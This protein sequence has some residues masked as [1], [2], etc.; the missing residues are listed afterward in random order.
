M[1]YFLDTYAIMEIIKG[2]PAYD[3]FVDGELFTSLFNLYELYYNLLEDCG[4]AI[5]QKYFY[6]FY[7]SLIPITDNH[8]F[9]ASVF[10]LQY[11]KSKVSYTDAL[12]YVMAVTE[13]MKFLTG[14]KAFEYIEN[15]EWVK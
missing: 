1:K 7:D 5:A 8:I 15:V 11:K 2:N 4:E 14:D 10:K 12:G 13:G 6:E 3:R 9:Q